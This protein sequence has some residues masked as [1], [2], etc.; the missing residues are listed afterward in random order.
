MENI[1]DETDVNRLYG[2]FTDENVQVWTSTSGLDLVPGGNLSWIVSS[3]V[4]LRRC[5]L[6]NN[7]FTVIRIWSFVWF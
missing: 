7:S 1:Q 6:H 3:S 2:D 4:D 5:L